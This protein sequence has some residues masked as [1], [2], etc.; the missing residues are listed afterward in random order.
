MPEERESF[1]GS[2]ASKIPK[3]EGVDSKRVNNSP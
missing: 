3:V 2:A 1:W